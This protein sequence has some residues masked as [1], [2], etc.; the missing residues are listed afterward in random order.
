MIQVPGRDSQKTLATGDKRKIQYDW[1]D[2]NMQSARLRNCSLLR[3]PR[4]RIGL[5]FHNGSYG[6]VRI[7]IKFI[8]CISFSVERIL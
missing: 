5:A 1:V 7:C 3:L 4:C 2:A 8:A 6:L